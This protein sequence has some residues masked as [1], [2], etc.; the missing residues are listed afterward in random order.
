MLSDSQEAAADQE[1]ED[2][3]AGRQERLLNTALHCTVNISHSHRGHE[4]YLG[5][6]TCFISNL[7]QCRVVQ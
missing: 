7:F 5:S 2:I 4:H 1:V 3:L 6:Y